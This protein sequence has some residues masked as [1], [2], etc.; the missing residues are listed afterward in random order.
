MCNYKI[1]GTQYFEAYK[2]LKM[3]TLIIEKL[4]TKGVW[5]LNLNVINDIITILYLF[6]S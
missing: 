6:E 2:R 4:Q 1:R 5:Y 3:M